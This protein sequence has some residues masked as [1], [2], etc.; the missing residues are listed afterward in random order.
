VEPSTS[1][2]FRNSLVAGNLYSPECSF[3]VGSEGGNLDSADSCYFRGSRDR[4]NAGDPKID[5]IADNGGP[6]MT[7]AIQDDS[8]A[9]DGGVA[10][11]AP[12]DQRGVTRPKNT[13][14]D[15]GAYEH[16]GPFPAADLV[17]PE[18]SVTSGPTFAA[19][20]AT[21][22]FAGADDVTPAGELL[23][24]CRVLPAD[25]DPP[26]PTEPPD[27]EFAFTGCPT[28]YELL[29]IELGQNTLEVRAIDRAGNVDP[30]PAVHVFTGGEDTTPPETTFAATPPNP[31]A[32]R[33]AV[34]SFLGTDDLT[35]TNLLEYVP[36]RQHRRGGVAGV[37]QPV[38]LL[39]PHHRP[40]HRA[41]T[42]HRR[43]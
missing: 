34:F 13:A 7:H 28:P 23:F 22:T 19:E 35:P 3:A 18:T 25:M 39:Q 33:T 16:E 30:S 20:R 37:C 11:C 26:D 17:P 42:C 12:V 24:E 10:P 8:F 21:F 6:S 4:S 43:G 15:I 27:P 32:G 1:V 40:A 38:E 14:C 31:S 29:D 41:G 9:L 5:A 36:D 2:I